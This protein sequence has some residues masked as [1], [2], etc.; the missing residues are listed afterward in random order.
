MNVFSRF[1]V[2][3]RLVDRHQ[4]D[5]ISLTN[6][7]I[8]FAIALTTYSVIRSGTLD[9]TAL[10]ALVG[11]LAAYDRKQTRGVKHKNAEADR[12]ALVAKLDAA[13]TRLTG[14]ESLAKELP[15]LKEKIIAVSNRVGAR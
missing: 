2:F 5:E 1:L 13:E 10:I 7:L 12:E 15:A 11:A 9:I 3:T 14:L 6:S 4:I 8:I